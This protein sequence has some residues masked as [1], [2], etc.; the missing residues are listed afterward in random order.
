MIEIKMQLLKKRKLNKY[1]M[2]SENLK[3][4]EFI[5]LKMINN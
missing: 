4:L 3:F 5:T 1:F 2:K